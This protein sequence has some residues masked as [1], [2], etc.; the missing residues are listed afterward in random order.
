MKNIIKY[1]NSRSTRIKT[2]VI[3]AIVIIV[4]SVVL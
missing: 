2:I 1:W 4:I 3:T